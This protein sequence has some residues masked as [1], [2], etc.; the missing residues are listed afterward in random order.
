MD[1]RL[2]I[3]FVAFHPSDSE[4]NILSDCLLTLSNDILY[5]IIVNDYVPGEPVEK[6]FAGSHLHICNKHNSGYGKAANLLAS[7]IKILPKYIAVLNTDVVWKPCFFESILDWLDDH[8]DVNLVVPRILDN[9]GSTQKLCKQNPTIL[10]MFSRRFW[11]HFLKPQWLVNYDHWYTMEYQDYNK[12]FESPYL[13]GCCM[14]MRSSAFV[15]VNGFDERYFLY[16][17]DADLTRELASIGKCVHFPYASIIHE[18]GRGNYRSIRLM[19]VNI[20]SAIKYFL[21]WGI[22]LW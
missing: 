9:T 15:E 13:S 4:V 10:G 12:V 16:L 19:L 14:I 2:H 17:E 7:H 11:P 5:S 21:K 1:Y 18:W 6:L 22:K 3:L 20:S 8:K